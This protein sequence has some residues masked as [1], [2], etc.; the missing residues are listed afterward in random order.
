MDNQDALQ[1]IYNC[2]LISCCI[3]MIFVMS[4]KSAVLQCISRFTGILYHQT[5]NRSL[6]TIILHKCPLFVL[7]SLVV[8]C[9]LFHGFTQAIKKMIVKNPLISDEQAEEKLIFCFLI[10]YRTIP[11]L[12]FVPL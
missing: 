5:V 3:K 2:G 4:L 1:P 6:N 7:K 10:V 11:K 9:S 8:L 12:R